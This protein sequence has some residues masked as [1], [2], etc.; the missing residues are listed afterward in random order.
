MSHKASRLCPMVHRRPLS[1]GFT[2]IELMTVLVVVAILAAVALP[3]YTRYIQKSR[4]RSAAA[5]LVALSANI[6]N[7]FQ[8][9]LSYPVVAQTATTASTQ[10]S[11]TGWAPS[12][13]AYFVYTVVS[14][15]TG[16][17]ITATGSGNMNCTLTLQSPNT[18]S[19]S[20]SSCGFSSW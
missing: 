19:A 17:T 7:A 10:T 11:F 6:E 4:A 14:T 2:L 20:G 12:M 5:D 13:D 18:R 16:Y 1:H 15:T 8:K 9:T 3:A